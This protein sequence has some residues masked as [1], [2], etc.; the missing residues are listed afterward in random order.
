MSGR[1]SA[2]ANDG[3]LISYGADEHLI[4][5]S[6]RD[7]SRQMAQRPAATVNRKKCLNLKKWRSRNFSPWVVANDWRVSSNLSHAH[8]EIVFYGEGLLVGGASNGNDWME[9]SMNT[10]GQTVGIKHSHS[11][12]M[13][14]IG[15]LLASLAMIGGCGDGIK[16]SHYKVIDTGYWPAEASSLVEHVWL[17]NDRLTFTSTENLQPGKPPYSIKVLNTATGQVTS[18]AIESIRC[19]RHG[20]VVYVKKDSATGQSTYYRGPLESAVEHPAPGPD[21]HMDEFFDCD[22]VPKPP[23]PMR[24]PYQSKKLGENYLEIIEERNR[25]YEFQKR[26]PDRKREKETGELGSEGLVIYHQNANDQ[27]GRK[28]PPIS[29]DGIRYSEYLDAY[30]VGVNYYDPQYPETRS[31]WI[32]R[33]DGDLKE[34]PY[35][36]NMLVGRNDIYPVR[37]G[38]LAHYAGGPLTEKENSRGIYLLQ[39]D[40]VFHLI[41]GEMA[42]RISG[43]SPDGCKAAFTHA[44]TIK[45]NLSLT[46]PHRT[47][48]YIDFCQGGIQP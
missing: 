7:N 42:P 18:T 17:D 37:G 40:K 44:N 30:V 24:A 12:L 3:L 35:P 43:I 48:K 23:Q 41:V 10:N 19:A 14:T 36:K 22:W 13:V 38:Y 11:R 9:A 39:G 29:W 34:I 28:M 26:A 31:F 15:L 46:K 4:V 1:G 47:L 21:M 2:N 5:G 25:L 27:L 20:Q 6:H 8:F 32:L 33:R 45:E 16:E